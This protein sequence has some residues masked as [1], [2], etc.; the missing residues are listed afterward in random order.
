[1][2]TK[3]IRR[4]LD[5]NGNSPLTLRARA[6]QQTIIHINYAS[7]LALVVQELELPFS[8]PPSDLATL[9]IPNHDLLAG[10]DL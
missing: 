5:G 3:D 10:K 2:I 7:W 6:S 9:R 8:D 1:M 4:I